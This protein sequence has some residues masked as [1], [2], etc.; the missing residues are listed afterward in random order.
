MGLYHTPGRGLVAAWVASGTLRLCVGLSGFLCL[1]VSYRP[2]ARR[3]QLSLCSGLS[4]FLGRPIA[5]QLTPCTTA[6][7]QT[8]A[9]VAPPRSRTSRAAR[10]FADNIKKPCGAASLTPPS[11]VVPDDATAHEARGAKGHPAVL[12]PMGPEP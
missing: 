5:T 10:R 11:S 3:L 8:G 7:L 6:L 1:L 2:L 9:I 4:A 12:G